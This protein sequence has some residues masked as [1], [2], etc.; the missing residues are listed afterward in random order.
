MPLILL[1]QNECS[2]GEILLSNLFD[3]RVGIVHYVDALELEEENLCKVNVVE[4]VCFV[5]LV[6]Q[7]LR[8]SWRRFVIVK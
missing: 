3:P 8:R 7:R 1:V 5:N 2:K 4:R 6:L